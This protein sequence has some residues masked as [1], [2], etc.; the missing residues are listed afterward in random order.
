MATIAAWLDFNQGGVVA[1]DTLGRALPPARSGETSYERDYRVM[2][3]LR[4]LTAEWPGCSLLLT[5]HDRKASSPDFVDAG[6]GTKALAV[7]A[8]TFLLLT[9]QRDD[10]RGLLQVTGRDITEGSYALNFDEG[11]WTLDGD[12]LD[13]AAKAAK[14]R[15]VHLSDLSLDL[16][17]AV[18]GADGPM[19]PADAAKAAGTDND[20]AGKYLRRAAEAGHIRKAGRGLYV[21][22]SEVRNTHTPP[23]R[24]RRFG[25][26]HTH[27]GDGGAQARAGAPRRD[28]GQRGG[29]VSENRGV[30]ALHERP[31]KDPVRYVL[32][33]MGGCLAELEALAFAKGAPPRLTRLSVELTTKWQQLLDALAAEK[34]EQ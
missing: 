8:D 12:N 15:S 19:S 16:I 34:E 7:G 25:H 1:V 26:G 31:R 18:N 33:E 2:T 27:T 3:Q 14:A 17:A 30:R 10:R 21:P 29:A 22:V 5:H 4:A 28:S 9:R 24:T 11:M 20:T 13:L 23:G 6:S 32:T